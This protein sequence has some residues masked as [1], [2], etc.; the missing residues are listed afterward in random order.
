MDRATAT[1]EEILNARKIREDRE[2]IP[3]CG[4]TE[5][6]FFSRTGRHLQYCWNQLTGE[7]AYLDLG[8]DLFLT[9]EEAQQALAIY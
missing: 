5:V 8:S 7:H 6:P 4:G 2:W 9:N 3:A 1:I